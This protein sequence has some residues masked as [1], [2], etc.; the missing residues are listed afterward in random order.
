MML[1]TFI[2]IFILI[3]AIILLAISMYFVY[4]LMKLN[5]ILE[6]V[7]MSLINF[8]KEYQTHHDI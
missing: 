4:K 8:L 1:H 7:S 5:D 3:S 6:Q 2:N